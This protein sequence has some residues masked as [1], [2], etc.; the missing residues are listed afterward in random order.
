VIFSS[1]GIADAAATWYEFYQKHQRQPADSEKTLSQLSPIFGLNESYRPMPENRTVV[2]PLLIAAVA[3]ALV[4]FYVRTR[5]GSGTKEVAE[6]APVASV[7][8]G[9]SS[10]GA[11]GSAAGPSQPP[12]VVSAPAV[13]I[14]KPAELAGS[15]FTPWMS[16]LAL[17]T[18]IRAKNRGN[19]GNFWEQGHWIR[20]VEG[21]WHGDSHEFRIAIGTFAEGERFRWY[22]RIDMAEAE[23]VETRGRLEAEGYRLFQSHSYS[24]PDRTKRFQ[25]VW[26]KEPGPAASGAGG[27]DLASRVGKS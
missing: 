9:E 3:A 11:P 26:R 8:T 21:R 17:D 19:R 1:C 13:P 10:I 18:Y 6:I 5:P 24:R 16:P 22:Y 20:A 15:D 7:V 27:E 14:L 25:A 2:M 23:F 12:A 4:A